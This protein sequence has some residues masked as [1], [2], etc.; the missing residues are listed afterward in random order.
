MPVTFD[1]GALIDALTQRVFDQMTEADVDN[2]GDVDVGERTR[3]ARDVRGL[4]D[5]TADAHLGGG[6]LPI[7]PYVNAYRNFVTQVTGR[8]DPGTGRVRDTDLP[9]VVYESVLALRR[10][11]APAP[12]NSLDRLYAESGRNGWTDDELM[13]FITA[14][15]RRGVLNDYGTQIINA[16][17]DPHAPAD[18]HAGARFFEALAWYN[19]ATVIQSRDGRFTRADLRTS[20]N[21]AVQKYLQ[22]AL[23]SPDDVNGR[24]QAWKGVQKLKLLEREIDRRAANG[25]GAFYPYRPRAMMTVDPNSPWNRANTV[26]SR[27]EFEQRVIRG[28]YDKPVL[29]KYG[30]PYCMHCLL[31]E[32][33]GSVPAVADKYGS[34]LDVVKLWWNP[35][36]PQMREITQ[37]AQEQGVTSS[38]FFIVY[39]NGQP[40]RSGYAFP[41]ENGN[42]LEELLRGVV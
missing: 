23:R 9:G 13:T 4:A 29:V 28:S 16:V 15:D 26:D 37:V 2:S 35:N 14:A 1:R 3:L 8:A 40:V 27:A 12:T 25:Q 17:A 41:D 32:Q 42:G 10:G 5:N 7:G 39:E 24:I 34:D 30:L 33:L 21:A 18:S 11:S 36:D 6:P 19:D 20:Q 22:I 31:L 38:P